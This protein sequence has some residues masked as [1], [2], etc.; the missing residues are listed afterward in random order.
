MVGSRGEKRMVKTAA[1]PLNQA[2]TRPA[3]ATRLGVAAAVV[4][5]AS[6]STEPAT[7]A[8][9][10]RRGSKR[11]ERSDEEEIDMTQPPAKR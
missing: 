9:R 4:A 6:Q 11:G 8:Q 5:G 3:A 2:R 1:R 7:G 10:E